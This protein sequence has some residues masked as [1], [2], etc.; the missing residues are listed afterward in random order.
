MLHVLSNPVYILEYLLHQTRTTE[1]AIVKYI[2]NYFCQN[3]AIGLII[4]ATSQYPLLHCLLANL[5]TNQLAVKLVTN[6]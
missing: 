4:M 1:L 3:R 2:P 6:W 5:A